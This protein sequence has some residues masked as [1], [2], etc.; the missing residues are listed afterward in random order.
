MNATG[1]TVTVV[2]IRMKSSESG[3]LVSDDSD[4]GDVITSPREAESVDSTSLA[5]GDDNSENGVPVFITE[6]PSSPLSRATK[7]SKSSRV[8]IRSPAEG[9]LRFYH[10]STLRALKTTIVVFN[11]IS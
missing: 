4:H 8:T 3:S 10:F 2:D 7:R 11:M 6:Q 1:Q 9:E 5:E